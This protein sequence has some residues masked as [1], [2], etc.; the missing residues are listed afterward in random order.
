MREHSSED[1]RVSFFETSKHTENTHAMKTEKATIIRE[2]T[3][4][5]IW[6][7]EKQE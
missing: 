2:G 4:V 6:K 7:P 1:R 3:S 5:T